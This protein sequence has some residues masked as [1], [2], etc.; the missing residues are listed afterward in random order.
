MALVREVAER[1]W[2]EIERARAEL[3]L[4][5]SEARFR[6]LAETIPQLVW[7]S[8]ADA[9]W[10]YASRQWTVYTGQSEAEAIGLGWLDAVHPDDRVLPWRQ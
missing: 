7:T 2:V 8:I 4:R 10:T 9:H 1:A 3:N 5:E 6:T